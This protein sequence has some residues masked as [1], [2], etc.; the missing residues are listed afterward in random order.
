MILDFGS[1][2][3][4][5]IGFGHLHFLRMVNEWLGVGGNAHIMDAMIQIR[6]GIVFLKRK[7]N[8]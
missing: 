1:G 6:P 5:V 3:S 7:K 4:N 2:A 8:R